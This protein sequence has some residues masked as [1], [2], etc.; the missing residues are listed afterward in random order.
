MLP[1]L[2]DIHLTETIHESTRCRIHRGR[3]SDGTPVI[4]KELQPERP[5]PVQIAWFRREYEVQHGLD[6]D[7]VVKAYALLPHEWTWVIVVEDFGG[8]SLDR[9][10]AMG[11]H[12]PGRAGHTSAGRTWSIAERLRIAL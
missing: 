11:A 8:T 7:C 3:R 6:L 4:V 9:L 12:A 10:F 2:T 1:N 5:E